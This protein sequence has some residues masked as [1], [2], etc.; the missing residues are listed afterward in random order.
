[1]YGPPKEVKYLETLKVVT[2]SKVL[3][4]YKNKKEKKPVVTLDIR[5][6]RIEWIESRLYSF[7]ERNKTSTNNVFLL[8]YITPAKE[9]NSFHIYFCLLLLPSSTAEGFQVIYV[10][11]YYIMRDFLEEIRSNKVIFLHPIFISY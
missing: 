4:I 2:V 3:V 10:F 5:E 6:L 8:N 7:R 11:I 1:M 9:S